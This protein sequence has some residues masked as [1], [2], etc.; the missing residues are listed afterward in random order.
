MFVEHIVFG[1]GIAILVG[2]AA[3]WPEG[4]DH[5]WIVVAGAAAPDAD[6]AIDLLHWAVPGIIPPGL[7]PLPFHGWFHTLGFLIL[8]AVG[9]GLI[10]PR[11]GVGAAT[12]FLLAGIGF[13]THLV[14]DALVDSLPGYP[15]L[16]PLSHAR[17]MVPAFPGER[18]LLG[19]ANTE[20]LAVALGFVAAAVLVRGATGRQRLRRPP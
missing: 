14:E 11:V 9:S 12:A 2:M 10:L 1:I 5:S 4:R 3:K 16:W 17:F 15:Y 18:D 20:S 19:L 7:L 6:I 8:F 13:A